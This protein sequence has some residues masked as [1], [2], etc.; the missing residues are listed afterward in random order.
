MTVLNKNNSNRNWHVAY[1]SVGV[2]FV[3]AVEAGQRQGL[4]SLGQRSNEFGLETP[5]PPSFERCPAS[6]PD[7]I[8][9][10][11]IKMLVV[12]W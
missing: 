6:T 8:S 11:L 1:T 10:V 12:V 2:H 3:Q 9:I 7:P 4:R 5:P